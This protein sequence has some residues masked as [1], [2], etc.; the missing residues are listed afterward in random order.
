MKKICA[1]GL[2][3]TLSLWSV[4]AQT[5]Q[6]PQPTQQEPGA[7]DVVRITTELVQADVVVTDKDD[8]IIPDL[9]LSDFDIYDNGKKQDLKFMEFV[10]VET[11]RRTEG[12]APSTGIA[13]ERDMPG[14]SAKELK[15][16]MAF[17]ID[18]LTIPD[19][20]L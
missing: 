3:I 1:A 13:I 18:D 16:V 8:Q 6:R 19:A 20:D 14:V 15:R 17:V 2:L 12:Q 5:P 4:P 9:K 10:S 11:P 7:E